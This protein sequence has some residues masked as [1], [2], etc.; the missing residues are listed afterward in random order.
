MSVWDSLP[1]S[2]FLDLVG[3]GQR[4]VVQG[5]GSITRKEMEVS[6]S[7][8]RRGFGT[9][10][11]V[12]KSFLDCKIIL[13]HSLGSFPRTGFVPLENVQRQTKTKIKTESDLSS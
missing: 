6:S 10:I 3:F 5:P 12:Y 8:F 7:C 13:L 9:V 4:Q 11:S 1:D 2:S